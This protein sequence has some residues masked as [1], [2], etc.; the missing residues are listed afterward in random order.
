[1]IEAKQFKK[2][3]RLIKAL[4]NYRRLAI[5]SFIKKEGESSVSD[6]AEELKLSMQATSKHIKLLEAVE[7]LS[8]DQRG[9]LVYY[10][11]SKPLPNFLSHII[12]GL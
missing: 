7:I 5:I 9:P 1:M 8:A 4:A 3:E 6:M 2:L 12:S 11:L 10:S